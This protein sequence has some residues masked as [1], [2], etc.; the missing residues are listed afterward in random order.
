MAG[1]TIDLLGSE[2]ELLE[3]AE[4][5]A[6]QSSDQRLS[7]SPPESER[8]VA[9]AAA[10]GEGWGSN[11]GSPAAPDTR[12]SEDEVLDEEETLAYSDDE[13][14]EPAGRSG[15]PRERRSPSR[16]EAQP[17]QRS[18][19]AQGGGWGAAAAAGAAQSG[20]WGS[21]ATWHNDQ[22]EAACARTGGRDSPAGLVA[23]AAAGRP[24]T[25]A[26]AAAGGDTENENDSRLHCAIC[27]E[28]LVYPVTPS[29]AG[30][31]CDHS[32][33]KPCL[34]DYANKSETEG[35][36]CCPQCMAHIGNFCC[37][38]SVDTAMEHRIKIR[39]G[40][41]VYERDCAKRRTFIEDSHKTNK[42]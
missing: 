3:G 26:A 38:N 39:R 17:A 42:A 1:E 6:A 11:A 19:A 25:A 18:A 21:S 9:A 15:S 2:D 24:A 23:A 40:A 12:D 20:G 14:P 4:G 28:W 37:N 5:V 34:R 22:S 8:R 41:G 32:Y 30:W 16:H 33:C 36:R 10:S 29:T 35:P 7:R 31:D 13:N 27:T